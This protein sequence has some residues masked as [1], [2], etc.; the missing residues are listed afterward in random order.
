MGLML[1]RSGIL[2]E[3]GRSGLP[4]VS[5]VQYLAGTKIRAQLGAPTI[6]HKWPPQSTT[7]KEEMSL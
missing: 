4:F 1:L 2:K 5:T 6:M 3:F 7:V